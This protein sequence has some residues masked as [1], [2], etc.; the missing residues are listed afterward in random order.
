MIALY[1]G[2]I[3]TMFGLYI[4]LE[5]VFLPSSEKDVGAMPEYR[6]W[7]FRFARRAAGLM[8]GLPFCNK[9][10]TIRGLS[11]FLTHSMT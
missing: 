4:V 7:G 3:T 1:P 5:F 10:L 9:A 6:L 11:S 8:V 2:R